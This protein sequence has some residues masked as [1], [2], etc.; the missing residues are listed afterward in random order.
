MQELP[1]LAVGRRVMTRPGM[2]QEER[3]RLYPG[4]DSPSYLV[5][6]ARRRRLEEW[7]RTLPGGP[8]RILDV[9]GRLQPYRALFDGRAGSYFTVDLRRTPTLSVVGDGVRL[10]LRDLAFDVVL[11]TQVLEY[12]NDP[13]ELV[14]EVR[15]VLVDGGTCFLSSPASYPIDAAEDRWRFLPAGLETL[16]L[17]FAQVEVV[18]EGGSIAGIMRTLA[19][20]ASMW[21]RVPPIEWLVAHALVPLLNTIGAVGD[22]VTSNTQFSANYLVRAR[23]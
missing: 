20:A 19:V 5:L 16:F 2:T 23:K 8:L 7:I 3:A 18:A 11:C 9:G 14:R 15:R 10:P 4:L 17:E 21:S 1:L 6:R 22:A 13:A 12:V